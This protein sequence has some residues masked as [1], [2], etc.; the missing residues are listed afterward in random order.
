V[1]ALLF[2]AVATAVHPLL[3]VVGFLGVLVTTAALLQQLFGA[4]VLAHDG[5]R[6][7]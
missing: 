2:T 4:S 3:V 5:D 6:R 1:G 7:R